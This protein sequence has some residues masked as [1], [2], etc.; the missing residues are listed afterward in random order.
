V[1]AFSVGDVIVVQGRNSG[2]AAPNVVL[3]ECILVE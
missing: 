1:A 3:Q 2:L